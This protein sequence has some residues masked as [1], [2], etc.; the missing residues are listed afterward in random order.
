MASRPVL[1][2]DSPDVVDVINGLEAAQR[3]FGKELRAEH[4]AIAQLVADQIA[5]RAAA[6]QGYRRYAQAWRPSGVNKGARLT[7][8]ERQFPGA[9]ARYLGTRPLTRTGWNAAVYR[10]GARVRGRRY[11]PPDRRQGA[12]WVGNQWIVGRPGEGPH[13]VRD[14]APGLV[15]DIDER[16][17]DAFARASDRV[18]KGRA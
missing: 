15:D 3:R 16:L 11:V 13:I 2:I 6:T 12:P 18:W 7:L 14:V 5:Q 4:K 17:K 1:D 9:T 10:N 8:R